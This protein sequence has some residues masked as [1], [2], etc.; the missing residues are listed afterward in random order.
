[1]AD[2]TEAPE[3]TT[4]TTEP[5]GMGTPAQTEAPAQAPTPTQAPAAETTNPTEGTPKGIETML[6][7]GTETQESAP[8]AYQDFEGEGGRKFSPE[9]VKGF[10]TAAK[11][12][13]LTQ[14][15]AQKLFSAMM[16]TAREYLAKD[17]A[18]HSQQWAEES[19]RDPEFG[20]DALPQSLAIIRQACQAYATPELRK[21]LNASGLGNHPEVL[22]HFYRIGKTMQQD[23]GVAGSAS[24]PAAKRS[25][26]PKSNMVLDI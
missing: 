19:K 2:T 15:K 10:T 18:E 14:E 4:Q 8:E 13:G 17:L 25:R 22:R 26:Y 1:M 5:T 7:D 9:Q 24:A 20:G 6:G 12:L 11:E 23:N 3:G 16:P 21:L